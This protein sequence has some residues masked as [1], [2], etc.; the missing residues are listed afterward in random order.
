MATAIMTKPSTSAAPRARHHSH[1]RAPPQRPTDRGLG[2]APGGRRG[3]GAAREE[4]A[5]AAAAG[6]NARA[7]QSA[8][9]PSAPPS[10]SCAFGLAASPSW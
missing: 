10:R 6:Q 5:Q 1:A 7:G 8:R 4:G 9:A 3:R 2:W